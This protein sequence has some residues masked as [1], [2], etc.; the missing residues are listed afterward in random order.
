VSLDFSGTSPSCVSCHRDPHQGQLGITCSTCHTFRS[1]VD[2]S[3]MLRAHQLTRF[4]LAGAHRTVDCASCHT[5]APQGQVRYAGRS[6]ECVS[7]HQADLK[8]AKNPDHVAANFPA[9]CGQ[10]H[11]PTFWERASFDHARTQFPL[12][13]A[14][15]TATC[16]AC[17]ADGVYTGKPTTCVSCHQ[18]D[19]NGATS[20]N[21]VAGGFPT[22][23]QSCHGTTTWG[24]AGFD[25]SQTAFPLTGAHAQAQCSACHADGVY[26]GKPTT[27][28]SCH[29]TDYNGT[30]DPK[31]TAA[32]FPTTCETC[33]KTT[34]WND[35][36]WDHD[37]A[38][39]PIY[40][41]T[42]QGR[43]T[44]CANCHNNA[45][46]YAVF[47]CLACHAR[48]ETNNHHQNVPNYT[49]TSSACYSC[50]PR[51]RSP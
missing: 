26:A 32:H 1:F 43:W 27:C 24:G 31:H 46:D 22:N 48:N 18:A 15:R 51:G 28:V 6:T 40:S 21:H 16:A 10:C 47:T 36:T 35:A 19:Y 20:P 37:G 39:F 12:T 50:H 33:H 11:A 17:H 23:C 34:R 49:Y 14:H 44:S 9:Q 42:H 41:G 7:C 2:R 3:A 5:P 4:P 13:G 8:A 45:A 38:Y 29:L 25:H 30:T